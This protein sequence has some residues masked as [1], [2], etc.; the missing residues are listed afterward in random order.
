MTRTVEDAALVLQ[1]IAGHDDRDPGS[2]RGRCPIFARSFGRALRGLRIGVLRQHFEQDV[3][4]NAELVAAFETA[5]AVLR[6]LGASIEDVDARSLHDYYAVR[7]VLTESELFARHQQHLRTHACDY[8]DHFLGRTLAAALFTT[9]DYLAAQRQRR[10]MIDEMADVYAR[11][12]ILI[13]PG[14]GPAPHLGAHRSLGARRSGRRRAW[15]R[16]S[17]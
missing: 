1:A 14:G 6:D 9:A 3:P 16:C 8:G 13:T 17:A 5:L 2:A 12:D 4:A 10:R 15:A 7:V 11:Y